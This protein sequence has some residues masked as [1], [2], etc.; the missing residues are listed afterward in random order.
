M[1]RIKKEMHSVEGRISLVIYEQPS[2]KTVNFARLSSDRTNA[3]HVLCLIGQHPVH[4]ST[5]CAVCYE[6]SDETFQ[7]NFEVWSRPVVLAAG[8]FEMKQQCVKAL[9]KETTPLLTGQNR[10]IRFLAPEV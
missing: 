3:Q 8:L 4:R 7:R 2:V 9:F 1:N 5:S 6:R 10:F